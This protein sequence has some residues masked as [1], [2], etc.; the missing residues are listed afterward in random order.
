GKTSCDTSYHGCFSRDV[1]Q[2]WTFA[3]TSTAYDGR[4]PAIGYP[5]R[6]FLVSLLRFG[7]EYPAATGFFGN[8][9]IIVAHE[10][11]HDCFRAIG[12][13]HA[14]DPP[15]AQQVV[16]EDNAAAVV[17]IELGHDIG[18][19]LILEYEPAVAPGDGATGILYR[20]VRDGGAMSDG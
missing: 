19:R 7:A 14:I 3:S 9:D 13:E 4:T 15:R 16:V 5:A 11:L 1:V 8:L 10:E 2:Q 18:E 17:T 6:E 12:V 20:A